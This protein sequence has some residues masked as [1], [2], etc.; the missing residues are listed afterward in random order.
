[1]PNLIII[2]IYY[3]WFQKQ[4]DIRVTYLHV[5]DDSYLI[6]IVLDLPHEQHHPSFHTY[7]FFN[8]LIHV[9]SLTVLFSDTLL[10]IISMYS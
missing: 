1:M 8:I 6:P 7:I 10:G 2:I 9:P 5:S 3:I 4:H